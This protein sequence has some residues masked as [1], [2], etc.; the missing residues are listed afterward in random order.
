MHVLHTTVTTAANG[1]K[2]SAFSTPFLE[3]R[4]T[5]HQR[6]RREE[7]DW[8]DKRGVNEKVGRHALYIKG[9]RPSPVNETSRTRT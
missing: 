8:M 1:P 4:T 9:L 3:A 6:R 7:Q 2:T 5:Y